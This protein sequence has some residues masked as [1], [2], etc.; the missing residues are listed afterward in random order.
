MESPLTATVQGPYIAEA[1]VESWQNRPHGVDHKQFRCSHHVGAALRAELPTERE[2]RPAAYCLAMAPSKPQAKPRRAE[3]TAADLQ[4]LAETTLAIIRGKG[5]SVITAESC[6]A[7]RLATLL[8]EAPGAAEHLHGGFIVYTKANKAHALG[9]P[10]G[11]LDRYGA[12][13]S[14]VATAMAVG[15]LA[16]TPS[17]LALAITG[18]AGP[19]PDEDGNPVGLVC[20]AI[21][22]KDRQPIAF[23]RHYGAAGRSQIQDQAM[24]DALSAL[25]ELLT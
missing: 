17:D 18:V 23:E 9:V 15:A 3:N 16:R 20:I 6:T 11:L 25:L 19:E 1:W 22:Q 14:D 13:C 8:S 4:G 12:V 2:L 24:A 7:G 10:T 21:A 5:L